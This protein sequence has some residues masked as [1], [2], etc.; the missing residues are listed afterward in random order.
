MNETTAFKKSEAQLT[1]KD[2]KLREAAKK[3]IYLKVE[4]G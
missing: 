3:I 2:V 1:A 4:A